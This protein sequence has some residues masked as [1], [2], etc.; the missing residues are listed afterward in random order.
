MANKKLYI[1]GI[2]GTGSRVIKALTMLLVSG[3]K[4]KN[5]FETVVPIIIDPDTA[6]GDLN[7][8]ADILIKY[9]NIYN[10]IGIGNNLFVTK[11]RT[12]SQL[13]DENLPNVSNNFKFSVDGSGQKFGES[14]DY[15]GLDYTS[16]YQGGI[17]LYQF[18]K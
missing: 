2:G 4:L 11:I 5:G 3:V 18:S 1:F 12:L 13:T 10:E 9:Q 7:K 14:I 15:N 8:T 6:N 16:S 17:I